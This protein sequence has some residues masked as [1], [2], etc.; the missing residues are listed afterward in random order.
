M[1]VFKIIKIIESIEYQLKTMGIFL[2]KLIFL[3]N[4]KRGSD[5]ELET[6]LLNFELIIKETKM[7]SIEF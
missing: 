6:K 4:E 2:N 1:L 5:F 3:K 7:I